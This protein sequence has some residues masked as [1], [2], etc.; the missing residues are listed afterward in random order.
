MSS[1][2]NPLTCFE[3]A[4]FRIAGDQAGKKKQGI[5]TTRRV[6]EGFTETLVKREIAIP[7]SPAC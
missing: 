1:N 6:S 5:I 4:R 7:R 2:H 3:V